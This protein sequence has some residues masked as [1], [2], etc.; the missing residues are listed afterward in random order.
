MLVPFI[1]WSGNP[2]AINPNN[3]AFIQ[4]AEP[5][6]GAEPSVN[7]GTMITTNVPIRVLDVV[8]IHVRD[9]VVDVVKAINAEVPR[10]FGPR[11]K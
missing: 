6:P 5:L 7:P 9:D 11:K 10:G 2:V 1:M 4:R 3:V 8:N